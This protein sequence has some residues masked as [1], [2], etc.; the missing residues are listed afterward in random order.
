MDDLGNPL[1]DGL[2]YEAHLP[3]AWREVGTFPDAGELVQQNAANEELLRTFSVIDQTGG[4][5]AEEKSEL[6]QEIARLDAKLNLALELLGEVLTRHT[7]LPA[8]VALKLG[9]CGLE[10]Q[11]E[12]PPAL[13]AQLAISLYSHPNLPRPLLLNGVVTYSDADTARARFH[14]MNDSVRDWLEK[15][16]FRHHRRAVALARAQR[17][18]E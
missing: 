14:G 8:A 15:M 2:V 12:H 7:A 13:G 10:W 5:H 11:G 1:N 18:V 3:L 16:I 4:E 17:L 9:A 6:A